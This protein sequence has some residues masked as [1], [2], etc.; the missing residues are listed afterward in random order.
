MDVPVD[1]GPVCIGTDICKKH[2]SALFVLVKLF[3]MLSLA[4]NSL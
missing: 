3:E 1:G 4:H 2:S